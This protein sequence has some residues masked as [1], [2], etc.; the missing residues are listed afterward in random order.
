MHFTTFP[1]SLKTRERERKS[2]N[3]FFFGDIEKESLSIVV[4]VDEYVAADKVDYLS[5]YY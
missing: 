5:V 3:V 2:Q 1:I 4:V